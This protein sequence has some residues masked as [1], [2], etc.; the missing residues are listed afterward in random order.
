M[1]NRTRIFLFS[2]G[3]CAAASLFFGKYILNGYQNGNENLQILP[4]QIMEFFML[5][6]V[7]FPF[8]LANLI[9]WIKGKL[10]GKRNR[11]VGGN[12]TFFRN[13]ILLVLSGTL[14]IF[15]F[16]SGYYR[17]VPSAILILF[18]IALFWQLKDYAGMVKWLPIFL[19]LMGI[20]NFI[21]ARFSFFFLLA[22]FVIIPLIIAFILPREVAIPYSN[23]ST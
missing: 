17:Y 6:L 23:P 1:K 2:F 22:G 12:R 8:I 3:I 11:K 19:V 21:D 7:L 4:L 20:F 9:A 16:K 15:I 18:G 14:I 10:E 5:G 13:L